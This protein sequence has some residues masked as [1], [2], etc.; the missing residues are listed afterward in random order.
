MPHADLPNARTATPA[1]HAPRDPA[2]PQFR[3]DRLGIARPA[4]GLALDALATLLTGVAVLTLCRLDFLLRF[5]PGSGSNWWAQI[6]PLCRQGLL[7]GLRFDLKLM[8]VLA[9]LTL[10]CAGVTRLVRQLPF[11]GP[12]LPTAALARG[13]RWLQFVL[14]GL[15]SVVQVGYFD[16][17]KTPFTPIVFGF[18][19]DDTGAVLKS[20]WADEPVPAMLAAV[21]GL[22]GLQGWLQGLL[23]RWLQTRWQRL[24]SAWRWPHRLAMPALGVTGLLLLAVAA[25]GGTGTFPLRS[26]NAVISDRAAIN[27]AV[28]N[29]PFALFVAW[30]DRRAQVA[31]TPQSVQERLQHFGFNGVEAVKAVLAT[32]GSAGAAARA[33]TPDAEEPP[34]DRGVASVKPA[35]F[36]APHVVVA[37]MESWSEYLL[38]FDDPQRNDLLGA[39]RPHLRR[40]AHLSRMVPGELSTHA[41][42]EHLLINSPISPL[43]QG[44]LSQVPFSHAAARPF[45]QAGYR[46]VFIYGGSGA[47]RRIGEAMRHQG[48]DQVLDMGAI[49]DRFPDAPRIAWGVHDEYLF[50][51]VGERLAQADAAGE[52][53]LI[54]LMT[55]SN[56]PPHDDLAEKDRQGRF[57]YSAFGAAAALP[58]PQ[59]TRLLQTYRYA[60]EHLGRLIDSI[61]GSSLKDH[62][63]VAATGDHNI[64][65]FFRYDLPADLFRSVAVPLV[66]DIPDA[67]LPADR[68]PLW[69]Q[70]WA[71]HQDLFP[72]LYELAL[73]GTPYPRFG[74][75]LLAAPRATAIEPH[76][77]VHGERA[78]GEFGAV[79]LAAEDHACQSWVAAASGAEA[80]PL[81]RTLQASSCSPRHLG[82]RRHEQANLAWQDHLIRRQALRL[83]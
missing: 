30:T 72:T 60:N 1:D 57:D 69:T 31:I 45:Q 68:D 66:L 82:V 48:F 6:A 29:A 25:R 14:I 36:K 40:A 5:N 64:R 11:T 76:A 81:K 53:L 37:V 17:Y 33:S 79:G 7:T 74:R 26:Q 63:I 42:L 24:L 16:F 70:R 12:R 4:P 27:A 71:G 61:Q 28:M 23:Q 3:S 20:I 77:P 9:L 50:Q 49:L 8:A 47:W 54:V 56:H 52:K 2:S 75:N 67:Y 35:G 58:E 44:P 10:A 73:S 22:V 83:P 65:T 32:P 34:F 43:T 46:T 13:W 51:L 19:E 21:V 15:L 59:G 80:D 18:F 41:S 62:T 78:F 39:L 55:I 38:H